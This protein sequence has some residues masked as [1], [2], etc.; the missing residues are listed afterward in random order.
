MSAARKCTQK[1]HLCKETKIQRPFKKLTATLTS[2]ESGNKF[3]YTPFTDIIT[4]C[5]TRLLQQMVYNININTILQN[6]YYSKFPFN[7]LP[8]NINK[9]SSYG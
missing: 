4:P 6:K 3:Q 2:G 8:I 9:F 7:S 1:E 5:D